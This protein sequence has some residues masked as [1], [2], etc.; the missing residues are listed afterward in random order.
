MLELGEG[1]EMKGLIRKRSENVEETILYVY[2]EIP[3]LYILL[4]FWYI[5]SDEHDSRKV[6]TARPKPC[7]PFLVWKVPL[8]TTDCCPLKGV[9]DIGNRFSLNL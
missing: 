7:A 4:D 6:K 1:H 8:I 3:S 2:Y 5:Y 9:L